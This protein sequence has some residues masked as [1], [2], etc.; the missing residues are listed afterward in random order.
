MDLHKVKG[1]MKG[2][3]FFDLRNIYDRDIIEKH[4]FRYFGVGV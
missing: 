4:G 1:L 2:E 3:G